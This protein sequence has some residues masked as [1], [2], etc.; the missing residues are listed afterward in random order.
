[1]NEQKPGAVASTDELGPVACL[2]DYAAQ[3]TGRGDDCGRLAR[4]VVNALTWIPV[5][6]RLPERYKEVLVA[7]AGQCALAATGQYTGSPMDQQ[8]WCYPAENRDCTDSGN[9][10]VVTHWMPLPDVPKA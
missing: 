1:M 4:M 10:P 3:Y 5:T 6:E 2:R 7:F 9:D 8:G